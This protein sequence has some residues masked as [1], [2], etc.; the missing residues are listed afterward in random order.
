M[1][2]SDFL[3]EIKK[4]NT[5]RLVLISANFFLYKLSLKL[6]N[7]R[8]KDG[9]DMISKDVE[10]RIDN[11]KDGAVFILN[12]FLDLTNYENI[13]KIIQRLIN[14]NKIIKVLDGIYM[15]PKY[16]A[17][18]NE[19]LPCNIFDLSECIARKF[20]WDIVPTGEVAI[21]YFGLS[22]QLPQIYT[23]SSSGPY[24]KYSI[25]G[26]IINFKHS[27]TKKMFNMDKMVQ[28]LIQAINYY[29]KENFDD[30]SKRILA[31]N[32]SNEIIDNALIQAKSVDNWIY[33]LV[34]ELKEL[35]TK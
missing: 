12:D 24:K 11:L 2:K 28:Y 4:D 19:Y 9:D 25:D 27:S 14:K 32:V 34:K 10:L 13:K 16:S 33:E 29:G 17:L 35:K 30:K 6:Y 8:D 18:L 20:G 3:N 23:Y 7:K 5:S 31:S 26:N 15:K 21:N 1:C 22:T